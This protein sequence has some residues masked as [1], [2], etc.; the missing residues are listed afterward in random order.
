[1]CI[2]NNCKHISNFHSLKSHSSRKDHYFWNFINRR[3]LYVG[4]L[5][6]SAVNFLN[7]SRSIYYQ[8]FNRSKKILI[9]IGIQDR[10]QLI[11]SIP[12]SPLDPDLSAWFQLI[13]SISIRWIQPDYSSILI[14]KRL[15]HKENNFSHCQSKLWSNPGADFQE[16]LKYFWKF[17]LASSEMFL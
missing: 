12:T 17:S 3:L 2:C 1:M 6:W 14:D 15:I 9:L 11:V 7:F 5:P 8:N 13:K 10:S 16:H 4:M